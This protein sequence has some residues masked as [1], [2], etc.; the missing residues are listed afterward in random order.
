M[1][2]FTI[3]LL[4][5]KFQSLDSELEN[6]VRELSR[7]ELEA[8]GDELLDIP[9]EAALTEWLDRRTKTH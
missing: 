1:T 2:S 4:L 9:S 5:R 3:R 7:E 6:R 8:L